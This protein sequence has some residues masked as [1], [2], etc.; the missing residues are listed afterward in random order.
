MLHRERLEE[1]VDAGEGDRT[2]DKQ[3]Y[4]RRPA[5]REAQVNHRGDPDQRGAANRHQARRRRRYREEQPVRHAEDQHADANRH[6][7][8]HRSQHQS[9]HDRRQRRAQRVENR[10]LVVFMQW[11]QVAQAAVVEVAVAQQVEEGEQRDT[12]INDKSEQV[13]RGRGRILG[14]VVA[15]HLRRL[16]R[17]LGQLFVELVAAFAHF[18]CDPRAELGVDRPIVQLRH[19]ARVDHLSRLRVKRL[20]LDHEPARGPDSRQDDAECDDHAD[21]RRRQRSPLHV[22][23][24]FDQRRMRH[25]GEQYSPRERRQERQQQF[26][27]LIGHHGQEAEEKQLHYALAFHLLSRGVPHLRAVLG[28]RCSEIAPAVVASTPQLRS[29]DANGGEWTGLRAAGKIEAA[30]RLL[31]MNSE[32]ESTSPDLKPGFGGL[33]VVAFE[34][35]MAAETAAMIERRG[36]VAIVAPAMREVP[37]EDNRAALDFAERLLAGEFQVV[38]LMTGVGTR[39]LFAAMETRHQRAAL[40]AALTAITTVARGPKP[41]RAMRDLGLEPSIVVPEPNTWREVLSALAARVE[42]KGKRVA[43]QE[44]GASNHELTAGLEARGAHV[45]IVPVYRWTLPADHAP[46]RAALNAIAAGAADVAIF[47]TSDPGTHAIQ[48][49]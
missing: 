42:L 40:V 47:T 38:I 33:R 12:E 35:R 27:Q 44:Y 26:V 13:L 15:R 25:E 23:L 30:A 41:I 32:T 31:A 10:R 48:I 29:D 34:S 21:N 7:L 9:A 37:L 1:I 16:Q 49:P 5:R 22:F 4:R 8:Q 28:A 11:G 43:I 6:A 19:P 20:R 2:P 36:G 39:A 45:T 18:F 46:L 17:E 3:A 24:D 14:D